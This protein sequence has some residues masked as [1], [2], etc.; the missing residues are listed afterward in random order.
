[1]LNAVYSREGKKGGVE[2][3]VGERETEVKGN[4]RLGAR[5]LREGEESK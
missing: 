5:T 3:L 1:M 4:T 2:E